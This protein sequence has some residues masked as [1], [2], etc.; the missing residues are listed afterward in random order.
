[1]RT[2]L[3]LDVS[4]AVPPSELGEGHCKVLVPATEIATPEISAITIDAF[5]EFVAG[6]ELEQLNK[7]CFVG[8]EYPRQN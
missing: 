5:D 7:N 3:C 4:Q 1:M 2:K 6:D 8:H